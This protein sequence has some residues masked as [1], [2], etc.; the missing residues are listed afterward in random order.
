MNAGGS[1]HK[2][3][4]QGK[5]IHVAILAAQPDTALHNDYSSLLRKLDPSP[6]IRCHAARPLVPA[7][8]TE[9]AMGFVQLKNKWRS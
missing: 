1:I 9:L 7:L 6:C 8:R 5:E 3:R 2:W 4:L